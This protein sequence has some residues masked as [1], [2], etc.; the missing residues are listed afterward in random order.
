MTEHPSADPIDPGVRARWERACAGREE[1]IARAGQWFM[2]LTR[3]MADLRAPGSCPW[4]REQSL[5]SLRQYVREEADEVCKAIDDILAF[6]ARLREQAGLSATDAQPPAG[7]E[8][9]A[10]TAK[11]G[12]SIVHHPHHPDFGPDQSAS[13]APLPPLFE[14]PAEQQEELDRLYSELS[15]EL[16]DLT[17]QSAFMGDILLAM[18]RGGVDASLE[19]IVRKLIRRHPHVYGEASAADSAEVLAN[20]EKIKQAEKG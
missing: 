5:A 20:W 7:S 2:E 8:E 19:A 3:L 16:G 17:L 13:G 18:G 6:E 1:Q 15:E 14:L 12:H 4:D 9:K 10:R 11:K